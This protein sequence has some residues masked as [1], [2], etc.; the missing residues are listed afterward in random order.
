MEAETALELP[1]GECWQ[2]EPKYDGFRC[3]G[4]RSAESS[5]L[6]SKNQKPLQRFFP[7]VGAALLALPAGTV[8]DGEILSPAGFEALQLR[9]H[10]AASRVERLSREAPCHLVLFDIL[11]ADGVSL[12]DWHLKERRQ[13]LED[14]AARVLPASGLVLGKRTLSLRT[15]RSWLGR[16]GTDGLMA[17]RLDEPYLPGKRKMLKHKQWITYDCVVG[18]LAWTGDTLEHLLLGLYDE[19][20]RLHYVGRARVGKDAKKETEDLVGP[21]M[22]GPGFTGRSPGIES[23]W[24]GK[25]TRTTNLEPRLVAEVS[26]D[27]V[28]GGW[29]RHGARFVRWR[30]DKDPSACMLDQFERPGAS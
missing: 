22:G 20:G 17:K 21:L 16:A 1:K 15:A 14:L 4:H 2:Y 3:L 30:P 7:E 11:A 24:G 18:G 26:T 25:K 23:R 9:L 10:P 29:M 6:M 19:D 5:A 28:S 8:V 27:H 13:A 12:L